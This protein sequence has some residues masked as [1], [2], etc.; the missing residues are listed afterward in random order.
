M[1]RAATFYSI[2]AA[3]AAVMIFPAEGRAQFPRTTLIEEFT[4]A[5]CKP[6]TTAT[7]ILNNIVATQAPR[8]VTIRYHLNFPLPGDP[9][10]VAAKP[11]NDARRTY[12]GATSLPYGRLDG[13][14][15]VSVTEEGEVQDKV[16]DRLNVESPIKIDVTQTREGNRI[17]VKVTLTAGENGLEGGNFKLHV[18]ATEAFI[19]SD[20]FQNEPFNKES[21]FYD[22]MRK[23]I[24]GPDGT[25]MTLSPN[26]KR[27]LDF[28]YELGNDWQP[29]QMF[30]VA[31]VQNDVSKQIVQT[32]YSLP[33]AASAPGEA[34]L[35]GYLL[36]PTYPN[37]A[38]GHA[39]VSYAIGAPERVT[40][41]LHNMVGERVMSF[42][43]GMKESGDHTLPIDLSAI[44]AGLYTCTISAGRFHATEK[45][46]VVR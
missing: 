43:E 15:T 36:N 3:A 17:N 18:V 13:A 25:D 31:F 23:M 5:T 45:L 21:E 32:G 6:C 24:P 22:V 20:A 46:T 2:L 37:P 16:E 40:I 29:N 34:P 35:A 9:W 27:T 12:Y 1:R 11:D 38:T 10:Y 19:H 7:P 26:Q 14:T 44:P 42:E 33:E 30:T 28:S 8:V 4:S 41:S 39:V